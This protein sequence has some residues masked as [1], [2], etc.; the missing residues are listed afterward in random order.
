MKLI[1]GRI[2][3]FFK[4]SNMPET[5]QQAPEPKKETVKE[6]K[7]KFDLTVHE[8]DLRQAQAKRVEQARA[9]DLLEQRADLQTLVPG[10]DMK[11][12]DRCVGTD[13]IHQL[14]AMSNLKIG[15][16]AAQR[17]FGSGLSAAGV[18]TL[19]RYLNQNMLDEVQQIA[20][21]FQ[22]LEHRMDV[23][24]V[25]LALREKVTS[26]ALDFNRVS[27]TPNAAAPFE[28]GGVVPAYV[29]TLTRVAVTGPEGIVLS[30]TYLPE[31]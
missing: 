31:K 23:E 24:K 22:M 17:D 4:T 30:E 25:P 7:Q 16:L 15:L 3:R 21:D 1:Y 11:A 9:M 19:N 12:F 28:T 18:T 8:E 27:I 6:L 14:D 13:Y 2:K 26:L 10:I 29:R 20:F 5:Q